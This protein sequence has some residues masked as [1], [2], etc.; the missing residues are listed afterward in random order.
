MKPLQLFAIALLLPVAALASTESDWPMQPFEPNSQDYPSLQR[1]FALYVNYCEGCHSL[2]YQRYERTADDLDLPYDIVLKNLIFTD[3]KIGSLIT[4][5]MPEEPSKAWFG[6]APPDL[7]LVAKLRGA[8]WVYNYLN[9]FYVDPTRPFG[10]NNKVFPNVGM[11]HALLELQ[12]TPMYPSCHQVPKHAANGGE[13]RDPLVPGKVITEEQCNFIDVVE[14]TGKLTP[15]EFEQATYD[16]T[17]FLYYVAEPAR[18]DRYRLGVYVLL[19]LVVL[20]A[21]TALLGREYGKEFH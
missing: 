6:I 4:N 13:M 16:I 17:N 10:V 14:G 12:G 18:Q 2:K 5:A 11:P 7:T 9:A 19:F 21:V 20:Y 3:Q 1:G 15:E 8:E